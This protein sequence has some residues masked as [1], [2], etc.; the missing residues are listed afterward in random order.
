MM[1]S[2]ESVLIEEC[3]Q[4]TILIVENR[5]SLRRALRNWLEVMF[6][7]CLIIEAAN[8]AEALTTAQ[9]DLPQVII[10]DLGFPNASDLEIIAQLK[11]SV[12]NTQIVV[13][14]N[15]ED[16]IYNNL[17]TVHGASAYIPKHLLLSQLQPTLTSL[18]LSP[19]P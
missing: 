16:K 8:T 19:T 7:E 15:Y 1:E 2:R 6:A 4:A 9:A 5:D 14:S 10:M 17:V 12:P 3:M 18:L 11:A 13:L